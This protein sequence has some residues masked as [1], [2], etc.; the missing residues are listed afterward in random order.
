MNDEKDDLEQKIIFDKM[1]KR[2]DNIYNKLRQQ[3]VKL[4]IIIKVKDEICSKLW[5]LIDLIE[6][7][8][9]TFSD[10]IFTNLNVIAQLKELKISIK[11]STTTK[12]YTQTTTINLPS[13][14]QKQIEVHEQIEKIRQERTK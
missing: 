10:T 4:S 14:T 3:N 9:D 1:I 8:K 11:E 5:P 12:S 2:L 7:L 13:K 6:I